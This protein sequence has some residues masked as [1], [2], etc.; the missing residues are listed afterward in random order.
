MF[1]EPTVFVLGAGSSW[2]FGQPTG[3]QLVSLV[4][5]EA[6][7]LRDHYGQ[8][9]PVLLS[10][11]A[12]SKGTAPPGASYAPLINAAKGDC[13]E[14][15]RRLEAVN[16]PVIDYFLAHNPSLRDVGRF[17]IALTI[18]KAEAKWAARG[19]NNNRSPRREP[20]SPTTDRDDWMRF[21]LN[22]LMN[23]CSS[24]D[25]LIQENHVNF[26]T[27]NYDTSLERRLFKGLKATEK[28]EAISTEAFFENNRVIHLYGQ[29]GQH[30]D[31]T[32]VVSPAPVSNGDHDAVAKFTN[33]LNHAWRASKHIRAIPDLKDGDGSQFEAANKLLRDAKY[34]YVL[35]YGFDPLNSK[36]LGLQ[37]AFRAKPDTPP[38]VIRITNFEERK[39]VFDSIMLLLFGENRRGS[40]PSEEWCFISDK[41]VYGALETDFMLPD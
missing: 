7:T 35:G 22:H 17:A 28:F 9:Q 41:D 15:I 33:M 5:R 32:L 27:F 11:H 36:R 21:V 13:E 3:E 31:D 34:I 37:L 30:S 38:P 39:R 23:E 2:H 29:T 14:L 25:Q 10:E 12:K 24:L 4:I 18:M 16:P 6:I 19:I 8:H 1:R 20:N 26:L 40:L